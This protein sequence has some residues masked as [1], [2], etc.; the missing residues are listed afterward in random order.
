MRTKAKLFRLALVASAAACALAL[1]PRRSDAVGYQTERPAAGASARTSSGMEFVYVP[2]GKFMMGAAGRSPD[3][4]PVH[5]VTIREGFYMGKYEVTQAQWLGVM[6]ATVGR[7][8]DK[9]NPSWSLVGEGDEYPIYYVNWD[10]AQEFLHRLNA[11]NDGFTYRLPSEAEWEYACRAGSKDVYASQPGPLY[12]MAW[13]AHNAERQAH[14]VG[15]KLPNAFGL[16]DMHGN[17]WEWC[18]DTYHEDYRGAP[19]DGSPWLTGSTS[20]RKVLRGGSWDYESTYLRSASR[21]SLLPSVR[22]NHIGF[23]VVAVERR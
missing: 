14:P 17:V 12:S 20:G 22:G 2:P 7:Q 21:E 1:P 11:R 10:E 18:Q 3:E 4:T 5:K 6:G 15:R 23:R 8:R 16:Y 9:A 19:K 13:Y